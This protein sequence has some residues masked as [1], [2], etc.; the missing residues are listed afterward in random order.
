MHQYTDKFLNFCYVHP[1]GVE[2]LNITMK[3]ERRVTDH[4]H[5]DYQIIR[6]S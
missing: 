5:E 1:E 4:H 6:V 3:F 2:E